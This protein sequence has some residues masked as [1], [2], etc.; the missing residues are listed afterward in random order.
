MAAFGTDDVERLANDATII[1]NRRKI[2]AAI[3]NARAAV[4]L[5]A[6]GGLSELIWSFRPADTPRPE[7]VEEIPTTSVESTQMSKAL[8]K[9]GF[10][11]VGPTTCFALMEAIGMVDTHLM[12]SH[13]RGCS[14][15]WD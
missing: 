2:Q 11:F 15:L 14:G 6:E 8:K 7:V 13:R 4:A 3:D 10:K 9:R 5:R 1:R 12:G